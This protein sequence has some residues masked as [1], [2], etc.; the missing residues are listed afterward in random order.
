MKA[1]LRGMH[2][3]TDHT[4]GQRCCGFTSDVETLMGHSPE[5]TSGD[6]EL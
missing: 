1:L 2:T 4:G 6:G 5:R 3:T